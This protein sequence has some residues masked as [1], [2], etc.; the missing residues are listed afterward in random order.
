MT[1]VHRPRRRT[2][3]A[4]AAATIIMTLLEI[5]GIGAGT[6]HAGA[7]PPTTSCNPAVDQTWLDVTSLQVDPVVTDFL[8]V[9]V[10]PG[11]TGQ[12]TETLGRVDSVTT[13]VNRSTEISVSASVLF[14][15]IEAKVGFSVQKTTSTTTSTTVSTTWNLNQPGYYGLY[16][17]TRRVQGEY[18][19]FVCAQTG[20]TTGVWINAFP[21]GGGGSFTTYELPEIGSVNCAQTEPA[22]TLRRTAQIRLSC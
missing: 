15:K 5:G 6:A 10:A 19:K 12:R 14:V 1:L 8:A 22:G 4:A 21:D 18:A 11:T 7:R 3:T 20:P 13:V 9:Y 17:G 2:A 16:R